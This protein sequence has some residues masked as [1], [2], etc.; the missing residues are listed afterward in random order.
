[1]SKIRYAFMMLGVGLLAVPVCASGVPI[2]DG[3]DGMTCFF[4]AEAARLAWEK[5]GGDWG[6]ADGKPYGEKAYASERIDVRGGRLQVTFDVT[7]FVT[8][9]GE[10]VSVPGTFFLRAVPGAPSGIVNIASRESQDVEA[11]P[12]LE[13]EWSD[14]QITSLSAFAD[15]HFACPTHKAIGTSTRLQVGEN[16][17]ALI[18]FPLLERKGHRISR[19]RLILTSE[20]RF[21]RAT[22]V[23]VYRP[24]FPWVVGRGVETGIAASYP[25]DHKIDADRDVFFAERY[26]GGSKFSWSSTVSESRARTVSADQEN[27]FKPFEGAALAVTIEAGKNQG[28]SRH[29]RFSDWNIDE[30]EEAYFRYYLRFGDNWNPTKGGGKLPG[31]SGTYGRAGWGGRRSDGVNGWSMRG[32]FFG[33]ADQSSPYSS[34]RAI[35][36]YAYHAGME[37]NYGS[38]WGWNRGPT[39]FLTK[40]RWYSVEQHVK[41]NTPG[42]AN[43]VFRA[44]I[45]GK[46]VFEKHD[47]NYRS[48]RDLKIESVWLNV[49]HGGTA[50]APSDMTLYLDNLVVARKYIGPAVVKEPH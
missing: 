30:P 16:Y 9:Q 15:T 19:A 27:G 29:L 35:G 14:G 49:Y 42:I 46:L 39:S 33:Q 5:N 11:R 18:A 7:R 24:S 40:N 1:M 37:G 34:L 4:Y 50:K 20:K 22:T 23:G 32:S 28:M 45:D 36:S 3:K 26:D 12:K 2:H 48:V 25:G 10:S 21:S 47:I 31:L 38:I 13:I 6:D 17:S 41:L 43:G 44:W 8:A